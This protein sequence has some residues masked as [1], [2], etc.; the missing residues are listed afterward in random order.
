MWAEN[1]E[2]LHRGAVIKSSRV[3]GRQ[4][5]EGTHRQTN[6]SDGTEWGEKHISRISHRVRKR[7]VSGW[8]PGNGVVM[9]DSGERQDI[10]A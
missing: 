2:G 6:V 10:T 4:W 5:A 9:G 3:K 8:R 7:R 1:K